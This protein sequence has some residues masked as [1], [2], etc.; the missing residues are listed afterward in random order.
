MAL[1]LKDVQDDPAIRE[2]I[3]LRETVDAVFG[4]GT[5]A[6]HPEIVPARKEEL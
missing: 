1:T 6:K 4:D 3:D 2:L 5:T